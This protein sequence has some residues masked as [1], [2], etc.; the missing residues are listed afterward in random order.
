MLNA[1][2]CGTDTDQ[3]HTGVPCAPRP[4]AGLIEAQGKAWKCPE[5]PQNAL[6]L[7]PLHFSHRRGQM[8][9]MSGCF[10]SIFMSCLRLTM[11]SSDAIQSGHINTAGKIFLTS[12]IKL[13]ATAIDGCQEPMDPNPLHNRAPQKTSSPFAL[14]RDRHTFKLPLL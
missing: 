11:F 7:L 1:Q 13:M 2:S 12:S 3:G 4:C 10:D 9:L 5:P 14:L 8:T 6:V